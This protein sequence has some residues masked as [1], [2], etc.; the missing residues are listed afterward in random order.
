MQQAME[1]DALVKACGEA[2]RKRA[3]EA[4]RWDDVLL[5]YENE[6]YRL[7][8]VSAPRTAAIDRPSPDAV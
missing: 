1:D 3:R 5:A 8:G 7:L 4:F 2:A 6:A